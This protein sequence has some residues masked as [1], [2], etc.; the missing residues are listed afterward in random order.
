MVFLEEQFLGDATQWVGLGWGWGGLWLITS[1]VHPVYIRSLAMV[2]PVEI[3][4][5]LLLII[6]KGRTVLS[7]N[8]CIADTFGHFCSKERWRGREERLQEGKDR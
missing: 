6:G 1:I 2:Q 7:F 4:R 8:M 3:H 5:S